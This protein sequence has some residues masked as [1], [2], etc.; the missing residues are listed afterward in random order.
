[1][2]QMAL[3]FGIF[4][5]S[6]PAQEPASPGIRVGMPAADVQHLLGVPRRIV[7]QLL[8][9]RHIEQWVYENPQE[10]RVQISWNPA[11][12]PI[13]TGVIRT[14]SGNSGGKS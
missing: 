7:R 5:T 13:V 8:Y 14:S 1:M 6:L 4:V 11:E 12:V 3:I 10:I 9:R 2:R